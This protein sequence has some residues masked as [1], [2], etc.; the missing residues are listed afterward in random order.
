MKR[1][2]AILTLVLLALISNPITVRASAGGSDAVV[3]ILN[4]NRYEG[5]IDSIKS[6]T[7]VVDL[8]FTAFITFVAFFI[9][10]AAMLRNVLAGAYCAFPKFWDKVDAAHKEV[11]ETGWVTRLQGLRSNY[12]NINMGSLGKSIMRILPNIK[13]L[14]DFEDNTIEPKS[15]FIKAIPQMIGVIIIGVFIYNGYYRDTASTIS[16]FGSELFERVILSADPIAIYDR[17]TGATGRPEFASDNSLT[18]DGILINKLSEAAYSKVIGTYT[19]IKGSAAKTALATQLEAWV[20][21]NVDNKCGTYID[22]SSWSYSY[23]VTLTLGKTAMTDSN[24]PDGFGHSIVFSDL[25]VSSLSLDSTKE[26]G[27]DWHVT[28]IINFKKKAPEAKSTT[29]LDLTMTVKGLMANSKTI[30]LPVGGDSRIYVYTTGTKI[31]GKKVSFNE[32]TGV[33]TFTEGKP[34]GN[35]WACEGLVYRGSNGKSHRINTITFSS[36]SNTQCTASLSSKVYVVD[37]LSYG[38]AIPDDLTKR[39]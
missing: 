20:K 24:T 38:S 1:M 15:Y 4:N 18:D 28:V 2:L 22:R 16:N 3:D 37:N 19:D 5:A 23:D 35:T 29:V 11:A 27:V 17:I 7:E 30:T 14:T 21:E 31:G 8:G 32:T 10:S 13:T 9:I 6:V 36:G 25:P 12:Q 33:L 39:E 26:A 34:E